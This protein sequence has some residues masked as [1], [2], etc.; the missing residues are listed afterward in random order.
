MKYEKI[1]YN[2]L[3]KD[4]CIF[5]NIPEV[6]KSLEKEIDCFSNMQKGLKKIFS[7][8]KLVIK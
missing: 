6:E 7:N 3:K 4:M 1:S 5:L 2:Q 8:Y